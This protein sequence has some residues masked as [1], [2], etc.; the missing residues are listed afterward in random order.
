VQANIFVKIRGECGI[1]NHMNKNL[2]IG[3]VVVILV[4]VVAIVFGQSN[5]S[6]SPSMTGETPG[7]FDFVFRYGVGAKNE[8]NTFEGTYTKDMVEDPSVTID[9]ALSEEE[10]MGVYQKIVELDLFEKSTE[11]LETGFSVTPC[12]SYYL[13]VQKGS[14]EQETSWNNCEGAV[15]SAFGEFTEYITG[16]IESKEGYQELPEPR[17]GY[18]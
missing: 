12:S 9:L 7:D 5:D 4:V 1:I 17:G 16:I 6:T 18:L 11:P 10:L 3:V 2:L 14:E 15:D 13:R 8:L